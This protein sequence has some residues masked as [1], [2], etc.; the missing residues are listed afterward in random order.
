MTPEQEEARSQ[1]LFSAAAHIQEFSIQEAKKAGLSLAEL[2]DVFSFLL[3]TLHETINGKKAETP[4][5]ILPPEP[6]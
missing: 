4:P 6:F 2:G 5:I 1:L 3:V